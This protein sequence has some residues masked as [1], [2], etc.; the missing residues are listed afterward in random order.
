MPIYEFKCEE[1][2]EVFEEL[3]LGSTEEIRCKKCKSPKVTKLMSQ[4]AFK[5]GSKFVSSAGSACST[6]KSGKCSSCG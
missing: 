2:G 4:V 5:T 1:C 3:V 6:C